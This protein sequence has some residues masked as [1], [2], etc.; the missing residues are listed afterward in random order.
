MKRTIYDEEHEAF[1]DTVRGYI[2]TE[3]VPH[4]EKWEAERLV[5]RSAYVAAGKIGYYLGG[6]GGGPGGNSEIS[7]W[8]A[9]NF[10]ATTVG[11][12]TV[13]KLT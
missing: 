4:A 9:E 2:E 11:G 1:R 3:L 5:D 10:T 12:T 6:S 13:Y 7:A 8:V